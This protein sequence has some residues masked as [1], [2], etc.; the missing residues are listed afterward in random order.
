MNQSTVSVIICAYTEKRWNE[1]IAAVFS[2]QQQ[3]LLPLEILL[4]IDHNQSL[5][6]KARSYFKDILVLENNQER[7]LSGARN[8]GLMHAK[9]DLIAFLDDDAIAERDWLSY[10]CEGCQD[11]RV[12]GVGGE[13]LPTWIGKRPTW[14]PHE[15]LW[16]VG[17]SY[18]PQYPHPIPVRNPYGG[19]TCIRREV[20]DTIGGFTVG[21]GRVGTLPMGGEETELAIRAKHYWPDKFFLLDARAKI[22]HL[23]P[24]ER[25]TWSYFRARCFSEG[26]SKALITYSVGSKDSLASERSYMLTLLPR[27]ILQGI[28]DTLFHFDLSGLQRACAILLGLLFTMAGYLIG[29]LMHKKYR[30]KPSITHLTSNRYLNTGKG[31][32]NDY[33]N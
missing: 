29:R 4:V 32:V 13:V 3:D 15:F 21:L 14:F 28:L 11:E 6:E 2:V 10:M 24:V 30:Q 19:C 18:Y 25:S 22:H 26:I 17:C 31:L 1:V 23:I 5:F 9:G 16:V 33:K 27:G 20:F 8:C 12:L 7:G